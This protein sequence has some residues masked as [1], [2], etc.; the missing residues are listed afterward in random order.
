V[1]KSATRP[2]EKEVKVSFLK[3]IGA[4]AA[5]VSLLLALNQVT[6]LV[7]NLRVHHKEF[8]EAMKSGELEQQREDYSAAFRNFKRATELDPIDRDAQT[9]ETHVAMLWLENGIEKQTFADAIN[10]MLAVFDSAL[11]KAKG[12][13]AGDILAHIAWANYLKDNEEMGEDESVGKNLKAAFAVDPNNVYAHTFFGFWILRQIGDIKSAEE[14][15]AAALATGRVRTYVRE[16]QILA[17][18]R[19]DESECDA[20]ELRVANDMRK[21]GE[22]MSSGQR[23]RIFW[24]NFKTQFHLRKKLAATLAVLS[25]ADTEATYD[26]LD[27]SVNSEVKDE[28]RAYFMANLKEV[29]GKP[30]EALADYQALQK[31]MKSSDNPLISMVDVDIKLLSHHK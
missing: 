12:Q 27:D 22:L 30:E 13:E 3:V 9:K 18:L 25:P 4:V 14:H 29:M 24:N 19:S 6:G 21:T 11:V 2:P 16:M 1:P 15:F 28:S 20:E 23:N 8:S 26:W 31:K 17:L 10:Q 7:Q 5:V